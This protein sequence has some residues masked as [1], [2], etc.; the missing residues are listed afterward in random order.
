[1]DWIG[2]DW[3]GLACISLAW[4]RLACPDLDW[5]GFKWPVLNCIGLAWNLLDCPR[6]NWTSLDWTRLDWIGLNWLRFAFSWLNWSRLNWIGFS[7]FVHIYHLFPL[8]VWEIFQ[9]L[10]ILIPLECWSSSGSSMS[11]FLPPPTH[12]VYLKQAA[13]AQR[14]LSTSGPLPHTVYFSSWIFTGTLQ[15]WC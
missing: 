2:L 6:L 4:I 13:I 5:I 8:M 10:F 12:G 3:I 11:S 15:S 1:M 14:A 7:C 9:S